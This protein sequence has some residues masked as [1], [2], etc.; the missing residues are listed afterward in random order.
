MTSLTGADAQY[1]ARPV[2]VLPGFL[3]RHGPGENP[4]DL[5]QSELRGDLGDPGFSLDDSAQRLLLELH[6]LA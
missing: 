5:L 3:H 4:T 1:D 6:G 2:D